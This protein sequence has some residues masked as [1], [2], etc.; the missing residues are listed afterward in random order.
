MG[1]TVGVG[2]GAVLA[3][4]LS[5]APVSAVL[6]LDYLGAFKTG[7]SGV[8]GS[9]GSVD[10]RITA[11]DTATW[12]TKPLLQYTTAHTRTGALTGDVPMAATIIQNGSE[13]AL[14]VQVESS[15]TASPACNNRLLF[16]NLSDIAD[17]ILAGHN[18]YDAQPYQTL[19]IQSRVFSPVSASYPHQ[20]NGLAFDSVHNALYSLES[21]YSESNI[22]SAWAVT[23]EP[24]TL[25]L[26]A[27]AGLSIVRHRR[28]G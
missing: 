21:Q 24:A 9:T 26:L 11:V 28:H 27:L 22:I 2:I 16:Y 23:P 20:V 13:Q 7:V 18:L 4:A 3:I 14:V 10:L 6:S 15:S 8:S 17:N 19:D 1:K 25:T 12:T 5:A